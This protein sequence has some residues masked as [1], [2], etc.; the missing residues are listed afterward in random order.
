MERQKIRTLARKLKDSCDGCSASK[1]RCDKQKPTCTRCAT[2]NRP[3][4]Y[5][6]ARRGGRPRSES[7]SQSLGQS[8]GQSQNQSLRLRSAA[9]GANSS[10]G[11]F[12]EP[13]RFHGRTNTA[14]S[15]DNGWL[16]NTHTISHHRNCQP[17]TQ[18]TGTW[19]SPGN[20]T[21]T[22]RLASDA[23][24]TDCTKVALSIVQQLE[25]SKGRRAPATAPTCTDSGGGLT[26]TEACQ[27]LLT[28][29]VCPCS[30]QVEVAL[31]V[32]SGC[33]SLMD[34]VH[35]SAGLD[36]E[37]PVSNASSIGADGMPISHGL[38]SCQQDTPVWS[39]PQS[40]QSPRSFANDGQSQVGDLSKVAKLV[41]Q[42]TEKYCQ[43]TTEALGARW[44]HTAWVVGPVA[45]M[46]RCRLQTVT[47]G[48]ARR[49]VF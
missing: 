5:S 47:H 27:R 17:H 19:S 38:G 12:A 22:T 1:L 31:L 40:P 2:L 41:F 29:L 36:D 7:E 15:C 23:A 25:M 30:E 20:K 10:N 44:T 35:G 8:E 43:D 32:A 6:P 13:T 45:A 42:F 48:V 3:C 37:G 4:R 28:I 14:E 39:R 16:S 33:I 46:L 24:E 26:A 49:L 34:M 11:V 18:D 9:P 21:M